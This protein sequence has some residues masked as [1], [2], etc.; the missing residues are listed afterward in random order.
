MIVANEHH[1]D[2]E[3]HLLRLEWSG[4][5]A[6]R[7]GLERAA[8]LSEDRIRQQGYP[9]HQQQDRRMPGPERRDFVAARGR[10]RAQHLIPVHAYPRQQQL[11]LCRRHRFVEPRQPPFHRHDERIP[12]P[13]IAAV[14]I[15]RVHVAAAPEA[16]F[17]EA[18]LI[19]S[20]R[21]GRRRRVE[22][23]PQLRPAP[24]GRRSVDVHPKSQL[25]GGA[26]QLSGPLLRSI[27]SMS[28]QQRLLHVS[29]GFSI[30]PRNHSRSPAQTD[31]EI[32]RDK[33]RERQER[34]TCS[35]DFRSCEG[36]PRGRV[37]LLH[38]NC[39]RALLHSVG[40]CPRCANFG[41]DSSWT[42]R[43]SLLP[44]STARGT[45]LASAE[46]PATSANALE[47]L[48]TAR[49]REA[50]RLAAAARRDML[51]S[52]RRGGGRANAGKRA[53]RRAIWTETKAAG[54]VTGGNV[55]LP[56]NYLGGSST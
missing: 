21:S 39:R 15:P 20:L 25:F 34:K 32:E 10:P 48:R 29:H 3:W 47:L 27:Q 54:S 23:L 51:S 2:V 13:S 8:A 41:A 24:A 53:G 18:V 43:P 19:K 31:R 42:V 46:A 5:V 50:Q 11:L 35:G 30:R 40:T 56:T 12:R 44:L 16:S 7:S 33:E 52:A 22:Q 55:F 38:R 1:V 9:I 26:L 49:S 36:A 28:G 6:L 45:H 4:H 14:R 17:G 37:R